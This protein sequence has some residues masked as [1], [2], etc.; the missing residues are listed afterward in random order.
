MIS[1]QLKLETKYSNNQQMPKIKEIIERSGVL[2]FYEDDKEFVH[3]LKPFLVQMIIHKQMDIPSAVGI[4]GKYAETLQESADNIVRAINDELVTW[5]EVTGRL[6]T[7]FNLDEETD[8]EMRLYMF[9]PPMLTRPKLITKN[10]Q[11][12]YLL[13]ANQRSVILGKT[14]YDKDVCLDVINILNGIELSFDT[15]V[16]ENA[17]NTFRNM[18]TRK[19]GETYVKF[20]KRI[21]QFHKFNSDSRMLIGEM[22]EVSDKFHLTHGVDKRGR[23]Y[24]RGY[25]VNYQGHEWAK[26]IIG[27]HN[28]EVPR[29]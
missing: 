23:L 25:H 10:K 13:E 28:K 6:I 20:Q 7:M 24:C 5:N 21:K 11:S 14:H 16:L 15:Y 29:S 3:W 22:L 17:E 2:D 26:A 19:P 4:V 27:F 1:H 8:K 12:G 18:K 9:P